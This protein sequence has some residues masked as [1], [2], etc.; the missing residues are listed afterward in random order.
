MDTHIAGLGRIRDCDDSEGGSRGAARRPAFE[1]NES[2][3]RLLVNP[4]RAMQLVGCAPPLPRA[5]AHGRG[6]D[7]WSSSNPS[8]RGQM[9]AR[10]PL[11]ASTPARTFT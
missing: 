4:G 6:R 11:V 10:S 3:W 1:H 2:G 8:S 5:A 9:G 7:F